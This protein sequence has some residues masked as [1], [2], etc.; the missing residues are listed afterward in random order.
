[1]L[2]PSNAQRRAAETVV[3]G[4]A[5]LAQPPQATPIVFE[6]A[7]GVYA[8]D[9]SGKRYLEGMAGLWCTALGY[10]NEELADTAREQM[11]KLSFAHLFAGRSH[12]PGVALA[13]KIKEIA[14]CPAS[15]VFFGSS[16]SE[17]NDSQVKLAWYYNNARGKPEKKK[18]ITRKMAYHGATIVS[19]SM[20]GIP[21][22]HIDFDVP[23]D[24]FIHVSCPN[25]YREAEPGE[26]EEEFATRLAQELDETIQREGPDTVAAFVAEPAMGAG[27]V[28]P[29]PR[30]YFEK[31][32][33]V[34]RRHDVRMIA[35][36]VICGFGRT[37]EMF[38]SQLYGIEPDSITLAKQLTSA[39]VPLSAITVPHEVYEALEAESRK[40]GM[41]A[42]GFTYMGHPLAAAVALKALEIY[43]R[44]DI[45]GHVRRVAPKFQAHV[46]RLADHPLVG[47]ARGVGLMGGLEMVADK[48]TKRPFA[49]NLTV[50]LRVVKACEDEGLILRSI[51]DVVAVCPPQIITEEEIDAVFEMLERALDRVEAEVGRE[52]LRAA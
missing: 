42:H 38:G 20:T 47:D 45:V 37:G 41:F 39:Y 26:S 25:M 19:A 32:Q 13:E 16:G 17:A 2:E 14:P 40:V 30:T 46:Q 52:D 29:P 35:D 6:R 15:H 12:D 48:A 23:L 22:N 21:R 7:K 51:G 5:N 9:T 28:Y 4:F 31:V 36:E 49:P 44:D 33:E 1:M 34:L 10:G 43:E 24:R 3:H 27:G 50:A 11:S 18:I 8:W